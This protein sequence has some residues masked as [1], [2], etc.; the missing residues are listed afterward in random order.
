M[1]NVERLAKTITR[2]SSRQTYLTIK[3]LVNR[4]LQ[5]DCYKAYAYFRWLDDQVDDVLAAQKDR[6]E[7]IIKQ[8]QLI[9][10]AYQNLT[11]K[12]ENA[13]EQ[14]I[15]DLIQSNP[16]PNTKLAN[17]IK[18]FFAIIE[19]DAYRKGRAITQTEYLWYTQ[20]LGQAV[21]ECIEYFMEV[22]NPPKSADH[23][24][25]AIASHIT[26]ILRDFE[27]DQL[28]GYFNKPQDNQ[29]NQEWVKDQVKQARI[30][31]RQ[32]KEYI[33]TLQSWRVKLVATW[34]CNRFEWIL[35]TIENDRYHLRYNY[36]PKKHFKNILYY[37]STLFSLTF[38]NF[39]KV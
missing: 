29:N 24:K 34:Y 18:N 17:F 33:N 6:M 23:Y 13:E 32:G 2:H 28:Q 9:A 5:A 25:A 1:D 19:F 8:K 10:N 12:I 7:F 14:L 37:I 11:P 22:A 38:K 39:L 26:H 36:Y 4:H 21:T 31:F 15:L 3:L 27:E 35:D 20:T 30:Y 16:L